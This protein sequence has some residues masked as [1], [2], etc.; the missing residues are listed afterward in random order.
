[1]RL[2]GLIDHRLQNYIF[3]VV[4]FTLSSSVDYNILGFWEKSEQKKQKV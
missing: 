4:Y 1:M 2:Q 3:P